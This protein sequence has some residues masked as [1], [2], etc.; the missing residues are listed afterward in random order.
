MAKAK[1]DSLIRSLSGKLSKKDDQVF[2]CRNGTTHV[3]NNKGVHT[4]NAK[5]TENQSNFDNAWGEIKYVFWRTYYINLFKQQTK[6]KNY[7]NFLVAYFI[8]RQR[9]QRQNQS[10]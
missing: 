3:W 2:Y 7:Y 8:D 10:E 1:F 6:Y 5:Q 4:F 9:K